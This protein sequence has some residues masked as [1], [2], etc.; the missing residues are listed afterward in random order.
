MPSTVGVLHQRRIESTGS[1]SHGNTRSEETSDTDGSR[2]CR[3][4]APFCPIALLRFF[5]SSRRRHTRWPRDWSSDVCS[6]DLELLAIAGDRP[7]HRAQIVEQRLGQ[8]AG[9]AV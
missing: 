4:T 2:G 3:L 6:S 5:F 1:S 8:E 9:V 7:A